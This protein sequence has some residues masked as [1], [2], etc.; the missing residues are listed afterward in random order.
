MKFK[1]WLVNLF[2]DE[3]GAPSVKPVIAFLISLFLCVITIVGIYFPN[4]TKPSDPLINSLLTIACI[5]LG[6]DT[7]DKFSYKPPVEPK[8]EE[9]KPEEPAA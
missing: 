6:S 3:R 2:E 9:P 7:A 1:D 4:T 8:T 5:C